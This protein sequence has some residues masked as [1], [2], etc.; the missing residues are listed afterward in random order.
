MNSV[1]LREHFF[2]IQCFPDHFYPLQ[3]LAQVYAWVSEQL[4][5]PT[6]GL[7]AGAGYAPELR[8]ELR[9]W[10]SVVSVV[11]QGL[12][13]GLVPAALQSAG[14]PGA[15]FVPLDTATPPYETHC[16]WRTARSESAQQTPA[17]GAFLQVVRAAAH[18]A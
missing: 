8:Y 6:L 1:D 18:P 14:V 11:S 10:L 2:P 5:D 15:V 9:H 17:L 12:G 7:C 13:V 3:R 16:L 4:H